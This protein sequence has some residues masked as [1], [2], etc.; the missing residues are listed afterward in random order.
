MAF[1]K[2][3]YTRIPIWSQEIKVQILQYAFNQTHVLIYTHKDME[4]DMISIEL[5]VG[6]HSIPISCIALF[7]LVLVL[8]T[9][10]FF[11]S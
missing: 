8:T 10:L 9:I 11:H 1:N 5:C 4:A 3:P 6:L 2:S 7:L